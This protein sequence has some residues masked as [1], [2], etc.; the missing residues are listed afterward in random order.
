MIDMPELKPLTVPGADCTCMAHG[1][2]EC[3]CG[4]DWT[5]YSQWNE[6]HLE[7][8][9]Y[10]QQMMLEKYDTIMSPTKPEVKI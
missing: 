7:W 2:F 5:D 9:A 8:L 4:A 1:S 6:C 3:G 10:H